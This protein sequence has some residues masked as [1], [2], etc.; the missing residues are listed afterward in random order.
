[1]GGRSPKDWLAAAAAGPGG[2]GEG[3]GHKREAFSCTID[4][5]GQVENQTFI[6]IDASCL[7]AYAGMGENSMPALLD[8]ELKTYDQQ[9]S[10]L[11][12]AY[13]GKYVLIHGDQVVG[14]YESKMDAIMLG[15]QKFGNVPF[16]V[17]QVLR[18]ETPME[19]T[20]SL[21]DL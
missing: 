2:K 21:I 16:L 4:Q 17:K 3:L 11:L 10:R 14:A 19:F 8:T 18:V 13:E 6:R 7:R 15:Y 5:E 9:R 12:S 20:S 1:L